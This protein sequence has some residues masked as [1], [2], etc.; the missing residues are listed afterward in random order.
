MLPFSYSE[1]LVKNS[2]AYMCEDTRIY[3]ICNCPHIFILNQPA[4]DT[5]WRSRILI[6][7]VQLIR[8]W[9]YLKQRFTYI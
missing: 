6:E 1:E 7:T 8:F 2:T 9:N 3:N 4:T 5:G